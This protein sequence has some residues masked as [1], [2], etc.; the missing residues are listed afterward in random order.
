[1]VRPR[2]LMG[3]ILAVSGIMALLAAAQMPTT[4]PKTPGKN[5][6]SDIEMVE[7]LNSTRKQYQLN[8]EQL[9]Q[10]YLNMGD[11]EKAKWAED[12]LKQYHRMMKYAYRLDIDVPVPTLQA[13]QNI[14][15][16]ND[17]FR[18]AMKYKDKGFGN[19]YLDNQRR[20]ELL[21]Q[22]LLDKYP[23]SDKIGETAY[24]LG[25]IY[26]KYRPSVQYQRG[27]LYFERSYQ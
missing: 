18:E 6:T 2:L 11:I 14:P 4:S 21:F 26:E 20:A 19:E 23:E 16:A 13:K 3:G 1:M 27:A 10:Q 24:Q 15:E 12:E 8:L 9:R 17:L 25:D 22:R 7:K 5:P